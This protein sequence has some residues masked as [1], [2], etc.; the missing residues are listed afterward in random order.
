MAQIVDRFTI[1]L[2]VELLAAF[3]RHI[4]GRG[5]TNRSEAVRD[6]I[7]DLLLG[8]RVAEGGGTIVGFVT[9]FADRGA[10][11]VG[12][13][14][15]AACVAAGELVRGNWYVPLDA[16]SDACVVT[17]EGESARVRQAADGLLSI[18]GVNYGHLAIVPAAGAA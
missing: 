4:A 18:R 14:V 12:D 6:L 10:G 9:F 2:D 8:G 1:S 7:R 3:D 16:N 11:Q 13:R 5:Y 15:R 17:L